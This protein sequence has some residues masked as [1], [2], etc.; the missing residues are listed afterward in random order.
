MRPRKNPL[1]LGESGPSK[2]YQKLSNA[3]SSK[4]K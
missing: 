4:T 2:I 1:N 3:S